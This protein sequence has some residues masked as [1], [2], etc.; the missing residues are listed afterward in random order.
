MQKKIK[1]AV[2]GGSGLTGTE[3]IK[4][5]LGH[6]GL[7]LAYATSRTYKGKKIGEVFPALAAARNMWKH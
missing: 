3:L 6:S 7:E 4:I 5:I 1:A 2:I